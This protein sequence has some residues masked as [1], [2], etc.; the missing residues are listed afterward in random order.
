MKTKGLGLV[1][2]YM[3]Y[4]QMLANIQ[5]SRFQY[6]Q[7]GLLLVPLSNSEQQMHLT[8]FASYE[9]H[10][11]YYFSL[12]MYACM[13]ASP[14]KNKQHHKCDDDDDNNKH[15]GGSSSHW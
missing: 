1:C 10:K 11:N 5:Y 9:K 12:L 6:C 13:D 14:D 15:Y 2:I 3:E 7:F 8:F 4:M